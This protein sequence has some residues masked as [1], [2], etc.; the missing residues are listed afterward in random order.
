MLEL[1]LPMQQLNAKDKIS[2]K[3]MVHMIAFT[4]VAWMASAQCHLIWVSTWCLQRRCPIGTFVR[5][6]PQLREVTIVKEHGKLYKPY[7]SS[8]IQINCET[9]YDSPQDHL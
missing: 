4:C 2:I 7:H 6:N 3:W 9:L 8:F 5:M 1:C